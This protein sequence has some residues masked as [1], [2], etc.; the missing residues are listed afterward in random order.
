MEHSA[1]QCFFGQLW[2]LLL[3]LEQWS[4]TSPGAILPT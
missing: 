3:S 1:A 4:S 2:V